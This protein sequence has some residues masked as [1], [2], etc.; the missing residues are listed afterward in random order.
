MQAITYATQN[1]I[2]PFSFAEVG[3]IFSPNC[4]S[5]IDLEGH[6]STGRTTS[7]LGF[8]RGIIKA[9]ALG[10]VD[11][12]SSSL[13]NGTC[14]EMLTQQVVFLHAVSAEYNEQETSMSREKKQSTFLRSPW[15]SDCHT[16]EIIEKVKL[17]NILTLGPSLLE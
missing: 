6:C 8:S 17:Q 16:E 15:V 1:H 4:L 2:L 7:A 3:V 10:V 14:T 11:A 9:S 5:V 13:K 12:S